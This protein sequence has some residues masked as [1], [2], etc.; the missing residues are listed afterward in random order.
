M[1]VLP[2]AIILADFA[3]KNQFRPAATM[4]RI[5]ATTSWARYWFADR[6][7]RLPTLRK[8]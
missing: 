3:L 1:Q 7:G 8:L 6:A 4:A 2:G 5:V